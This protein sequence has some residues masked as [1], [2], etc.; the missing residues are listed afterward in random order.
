MAATYSLTEK[1]IAALRERFGDVLDVELEIR[2]ATEYATNF[3]RGRPYSNFGRFCWNWLLRSERQALRW[4]GAA[5]TGQ[6]RPAAA[7]DEGLRPEQLRA[8][9]EDPEEPAEMRELALRELE[10]SFDSGG[11]SCSIDSRMKF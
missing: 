10:K 6:P 4:R 1:Q 9:A 3:H 8:I 11:G 7:I 5:R 2:A